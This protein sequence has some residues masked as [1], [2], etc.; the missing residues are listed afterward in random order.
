[1]KKINEYKLIAEA[2]D[3]VIASGSNNYPQVLPL[4]K[5]GKNLVF[6]GS[7][8]HSKNFLQQL[9]LILK[10]YKGNIILISHKLPVGIHAMFA[11]M[12]NRITF[13][14]NPTMQQLIQLLDDN[15]K[16]VVYMADEGERFP[17]AIL[18]RMEMIS[19]LNRP[20]TDGGWVTDKGAKEH[21]MRDRD[22]MRYLQ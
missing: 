16:P 8:V 9:A 14:E 11:S 6:T 1:M 19:T 20:G 18:N 5:K 15:T 17:Q 4:L 21:S 10:N 2:Y 22:E 13:F 7:A 3:R 12:S